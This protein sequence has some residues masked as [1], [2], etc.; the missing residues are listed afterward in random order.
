MIIKNYNNINIRDNNNNN[1]YNNKDNNNNIKYVKQNPGVLNPIRV[2]YLSQLPNIKFTGKRI[3]ENF[4]V[5][6]IFNFSFENNE[7]IFSKNLGKIIKELQYSFSK[8]DNLSQ[9]FTLKK[10]NEEILKINIPNNHRNYKV[11]FAIGKGG[12]YSTLTLQSPKGKYQVILPEGSELKTKDGLYIK[13]GKKSSNNISFKGPSATVNVFYKPEKTKNSISSFLR[14]ENTNLFKEIKKSNKDYSQFF[15][16]YILA[17][18]FGTR[19]EILSHQNDDNKP[20]TPI[21]IQD[22]NL[23]DFNLLNLYQ[24]NLFNNN[25]NINYYM[26]KASN[27]P[28]GCFAGALGYTI[29]KTDEGLKLIKTNESV[30]PSDKSTIIMPSDNITDINFST[31]LDDYL[32]KDDIGIMVVGIPVSKDVGG[33]I[34]K[35]ED[36]TIKQFIENPNDVKNCLEKGLIQYKDSDGNL[37]TFKDKEGNDCYLGNAFIHIINPQIHNVIVDIYRKK[38]QNEYLKL[39]ESNNFNESEIKDEDYLKAI[40]GLWGRDIIPELIKL[41]DE[42]NLKDKNDKNLKVYTFQS[43]DNDW[44]DVGNYNKYYTT[45]NKV[46]KDDGYKNIPKSLKNIIA[47]NISDN[48][49]YNIDVK[50]DFE[51]FI[52]GGFVKGNVII[53]PKQ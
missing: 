48:I 9:I 17:G 45:I 47:S 5:D 27:G 36:D 3:V 44:D 41:S 50:E 2:S 16:P 12:L 1:Y 29:H 34:I 25:T 39:L 21:P 10:S 42:G 40:E 4:I 43:L 49:I 30:V 22:W 11:G 35:N 33:L 8:K 15:H 52:D 32:L 7:N 13:V 23:I 53:M 6:D 28:A 51:S 24:A 31:F 20:S 37:K 14:K 46:A 26:Q 38:I 19:L 18:G